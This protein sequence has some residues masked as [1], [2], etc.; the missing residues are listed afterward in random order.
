MVKYPKVNSTTVYKSV[1]RA[2]K[3]QNIY[4]YCGTPKIQPVL[5]VLIPKGQ[6]AQWQTKKSTSAMKYQKVN[7]Y[8]GIP[9]SQP[10]V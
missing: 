8:C 4:K 5:K 2:V 6:P 9:K 10:A 3:D 7:Q 1:K